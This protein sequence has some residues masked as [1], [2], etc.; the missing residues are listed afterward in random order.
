[1]TPSELE[2]KGRK[3]SRLL[4]LLTQDSARALHDAAHTAL[5]DAT[6][7]PVV[8]TLVEYSDY[9]GGRCIGLSMP[10]NPAA[11]IPLLERVLQFAQEELGRRR[12]VPIPG[13]SVH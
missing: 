8:V 10:D 2:E 12:R 1:M 11:V 6:A 3:A 7:C 13:G 9:A 5:P 4:Q